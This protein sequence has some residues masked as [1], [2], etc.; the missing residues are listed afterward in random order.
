MTWAPW[1]PIPTEH[2]LI[3]EPDR[4]TTADVQGL[5]VKAARAEV[6]GIEAGRRADELAGELAAVADRL[7]ALEHPR[8]PVPEPE[9][10]TQVEVGDR[11]DVSSEDA[12]WLIDTW[13]DHE[14]Q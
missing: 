10:P 11:R 5:R 7:D 13:R 2:V 4:P 3:V 1:T 12:A 8:E 6:R 14:W 9:R